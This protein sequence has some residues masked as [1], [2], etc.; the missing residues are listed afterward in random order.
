MALMPP[1]N[2]KLRLW[3][4]CEKPSASAA[5]IADVEGNGVG[6]G[7]CRN[8]NPLQFFFFDGDGKIQ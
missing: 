1:A 6:I 7:L 2:L 8:S 4:D 3:K 5:D